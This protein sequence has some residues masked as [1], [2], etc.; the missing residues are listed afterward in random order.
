MEADTRAHQAGL[1]NDDNW[2]FAGTDSFGHSD[3]AVNGTDG[4][5]YEM[6]DACSDIDDVSDVSNLSDIG[7]V[8]EIR[9]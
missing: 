7:N 1:G 5:T 9:E 8:S 3:I 4:D 2:V 6:D